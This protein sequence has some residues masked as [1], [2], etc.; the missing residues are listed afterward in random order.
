MIW[1][2]IAGV[3]IGSAII[4]LIRFGYGWK[5]VGDNGDTE[6]GKTKAFLHLAVM[7]AGLALAAWVIFFKAHW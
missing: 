7:L 1:D 2:V 6:L 4:G 3:I 5:G